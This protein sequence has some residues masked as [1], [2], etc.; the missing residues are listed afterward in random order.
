M[1]EHEFTLKFQVDAKDCEAQDVIE[2]LAVAGCDDALI[3]MGQPGQLGFRF[4]REAM[5]AKNAVN[6]AI[7][8][9]LKVLPNAILTHC[10]L[11]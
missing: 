8:D 10:T 11:H 7:A 1:M 9:V 6:S 2:N 5:S 4:T 3:G